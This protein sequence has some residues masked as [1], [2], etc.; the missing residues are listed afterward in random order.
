MMKELMVDDDFSDVTLITEDKKHIKGHKNILSSS[1]PFFK[2]IFKREGS[3]NQIIYLR[4]IKYSV[5]ESIIQF[6]YLGEAMICE[7]RLNELFDVASSLEVEELCNLRD[8]MKSE[9]I[10]CEKNQ[11]LQTPQNN[12]RTTEFFRDGQSL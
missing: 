7:E 12:Q 11:E 4:G 5:L 9:N 8:Q 2:D 1:S 3:S 6:I 10:K